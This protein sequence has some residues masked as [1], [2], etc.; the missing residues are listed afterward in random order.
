MQRSFELKITIDRP[1]PVVYAHLANPTNFLGLQPLLTSMS[2]IQETIVDGRRVCRYETVEAFRVGGIPL[3]RN[4]I[5]VETTLT[6]VDRRIDTRV[7][8]F[9]NI[10]LQ[11][12]Y[13]FVAEGQRTLLAERMEITV[14]RWLAG[15]VVRQAM[16]VQ[17][18]T[19]AN[20]KAR[21]EADH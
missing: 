18:Q 3:L 14:A 7:R 1:V 21:L 9:P 13:D 11:V 4:R 15:Y 2:P 12:Y 20:L 5:Q 16:Q 6:E 8:S 10:A 19:L 17:Q